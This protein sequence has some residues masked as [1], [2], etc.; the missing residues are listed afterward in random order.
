M[1]TNTA[2]I[3]D[4]EQIRRR[5]DAQRPAQRHPIPLPVMVWMPVYYCVFGYRP[6]MQML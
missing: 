2:E 3:I 5:R 4:F 1:S 6:Q